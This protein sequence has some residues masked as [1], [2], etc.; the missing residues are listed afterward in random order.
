MALFRLVIVLLVLASVAPAAG[1]QQP[2]APPTDRADGIERV[3]LYV[4][5]VLNVLPHRTEDFTQGLVWHEGRL[6]QSTGRYGESRLQ[7]LDPTT[8]E[9]LRE[10]ELDD[11]FFG[12]G[13]ALVGDRLIQLTWQEKT[14]FVYDLETFDLIE[15]YRYET[16]G[17]GLC[18]DGEVLYMTD[19]SSTLF[20][21]D[22]DTF[23][24]LTTID[25]TLF[26]EPVDR[27]NELEC[28]GDEIYAN[29]WLSDTIVRIDKFTGLITGVIYANTLLSADERQALP[30]GAVLN[31]IAYDADADTLLV[32]GKLWPVMFETR[33]LLLG[34]VTPEMI[35]Q[36]GR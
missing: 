23:E 35:A 9:P 22:A 16:E 18:F 21:R 20:V 29:V 14:A 27:L 24:L 3:D 30:S 36:A 8:G 11:A 6:F 17:W 10:I 19:G 7:E 26:G 25:V 15:T 2:V 32:T 28:V 5:E 1:Q 33:L 13:L 34:G 4:F 12:E 31:G